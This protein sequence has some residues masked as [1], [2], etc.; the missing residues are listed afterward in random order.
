MKRLC[1]VPQ[2]PRE[3]TEEVSEGWMCRGRAIQWDRANERNDI[4]PPELYIE[5]ES[6]NDADV[7]AEGHSRWLGRRK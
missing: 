1:D 7:F 4:A 2:C 6:V 3:G 5:N